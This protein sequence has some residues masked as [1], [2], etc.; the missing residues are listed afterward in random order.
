MAKNIDPL[1]IL[2]VEVAS[3]LHTIDVHKLLFLYK[4]NISG[5]ETY[6]MAQ[7]AFSSLLKSGKIK[8]KND[9][10]DVLNSIGRIDI[11]NELKKNNKHK[12][13]KSETKKHESHNS[14]PA[15]S[16]YKVIHLAHCIESLV[17][18][19]EQNVRDRKNRL[20]GEAHITLESISKRVEALLQ[21][22]E[23]SDEE[24]ASLQ[25]TSSGGI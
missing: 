13:K 4:L 17:D 6:A 14:Q 11:I 1:R 21:L 9:V 5:G 22:S 18:H 15:S 7:E 10:M 20:P 19:F 24:H 3:D 8:S 16:D 12:C 25:S 2:I 23:G